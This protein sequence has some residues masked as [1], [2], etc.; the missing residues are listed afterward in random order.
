MVSRR[1]KQTQQTSQVTLDR[2][3]LL[4]A[5]LRSDIRDVDLKVDGLA[6]HV[7]DLA[8]A[9]AEVSGR[10]GILVE[11]IKSDLEERSIIRV[12]ATKARIEVTKTGE[13]ATIEESRARANHRRAL[14]IKAAAAIGAVWAA[15]SAG[16]LSKGC[17]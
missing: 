7:S 4:R 8:V 16:L 1:Q 11:A 5:E 3:D 9:S 12:E 10:V 13:I 6:S 17:P 15:I 2:V 14:A